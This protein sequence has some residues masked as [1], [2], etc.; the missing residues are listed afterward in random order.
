M[1]NYPRKFTLIFL[2]IINEFDAVLS[3]YS[4]CPLY[5]PVEGALEL[6]RV[7]KPGG[8]LAVVHSVEPQNPFIRWLAHGLEKIIWLFPRLSLGC[9]PVTILPSLTDKGAKLIFEKRIGLPLMPFQVFVV[10]KPK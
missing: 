4:T 6:Y 2:L 10:Q 5:D 9:R 3:T 8:R 1:F 7:V